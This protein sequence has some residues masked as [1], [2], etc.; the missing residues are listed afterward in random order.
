M[1]TMYMM[2]T[3]KPPAQTRDPSEFTIP[4]IITRRFRKACTT[5]MM[6]KLLANLN[7]LNIRMPPMSGAPPAPPTISSTSDDSTNAVS[8]IFQAAPSCLW[9]K[10]A[11]PC[12][13]TRKIHSTV[14][15]TTNTMFMA[16]KPVARICPGFWI[17]HS[18]S[19]PIMIAL[20]TMKAHDIISKRLFSTIFSTNRSVGSLSLTS[21]GS[22]SL[23]AAKLP[24]LLA[25]NFLNL[26]MSFRS[27]CMA[28]TWSKAAD[29]GT[30]M[31]VLEDLDI[32][33][34]LIWAFLACDCHTSP[35]C[36]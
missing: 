28:S 36:S 32:V 24:L 16:R 3:S 18:I 23:R 29:F 30:R 20:M 15:T 5:L 11:S 9:L 19:A 8:S 1:V 6:R 17:S 13:R 25:P 33:D 31:S 21:S 22:F 26:C 14:N 27:C 12:A 34:V 4:R 7:A 35:L 2:D 10:K